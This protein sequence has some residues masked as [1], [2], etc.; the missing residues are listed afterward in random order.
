M[1]S[2]S[3][4]PGTGALEGRRK[5]REVGAG[6]EMRMELGKEARWASRDSPVSLLIFGSTVL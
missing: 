5:G 4:L 3:S 6:T 1:A 2:T